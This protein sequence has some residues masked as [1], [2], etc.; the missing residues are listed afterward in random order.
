MRPGRNARL[1][2]VGCWAGQ[3]D[4]AEKRGSDRRKKKKGKK[5]KGKKKKGKKKS[6]KHS[7]RTG[8]GEGRSGGGKKTEL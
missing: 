6:Q 2:W 5:K 3:I 4:P 8:E 1:R 7:K